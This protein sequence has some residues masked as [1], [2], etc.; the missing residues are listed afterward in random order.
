MSCLTLDKQPHSVSFLI[1]KTEHTNRSN[2]WALWHENQEG[3]QATVITINNDVFVFL[4]STHMGQKG[5]WGIF[6]KDLIHFSLFFHCKAVISPFVLFREGRCFFRDSI[7]LLFKDSGA[8][9]ER[10]EQVFYL[11]FKINFGALLG[12]VRYSEARLLWTSQV[13]SHLCPT[14]GPTPRSE[15]MCDLSWAGSFPVHSWDVKLPGEGRWLEC[16][17]RHPFVTNCTDPLCSSPEQGHYSQPAT[18][19]CTAGSAD[20]ACISIL[21]IPSAK[22]TIA[23]RMLLIAYFLYSQPPQRNEC[24]C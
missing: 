20:G 2:L 3:T 11:I 18:P 12:R 7:F 24:H 19:K 4:H 6:S 22:F 21:H 1:L 17:Q 5:L 10:R 15:L 8:A 23:F 13:V 14:L 9:R 16:N